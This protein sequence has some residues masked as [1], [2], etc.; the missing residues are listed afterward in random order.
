MANPCYTQI[1]PPCIPA[2]AEHQS[3]LTLMSESVRNEGRVWA[4]RQADEHR[5]PNAVP[6][7]NRYYFLEGMNPRYGDLVPRHPAFAETELMVKQRLEH[8]L[9]I[10][11]STRPA[12]SI[13]SSAS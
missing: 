11:G 1:H 4:P 12:T 6:E 13:V 7:A 3:K 5:E 8:L 2:T 9:A 10:A